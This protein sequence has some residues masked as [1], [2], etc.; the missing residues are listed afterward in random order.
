MAVVDVTDEEYIAG[1]VAVGLPE[2]VA[3]LF[4]SFGTATRRG[5]MVQASTAVADLTGQQPIPL[6]ALVR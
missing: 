2:P 1:L 4:P 6:A 3:Q 5:F